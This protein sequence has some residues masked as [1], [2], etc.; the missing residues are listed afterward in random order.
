MQIERNQVTLEIAEMQ[1][2]FCK[3]NKKQGESVTN[4]PLFS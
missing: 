1:L 2:I 4:S 3:D